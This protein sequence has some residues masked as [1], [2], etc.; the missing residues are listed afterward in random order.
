MP[1]EV[2]RAVRVSGRLREEMSRQ[3]AALRDPR[4]AG[5]LVT[6][7]E[8]TDDLQLARI[9]V[10][11]SG[12][13]GEGVPA[14]TRPGP[15]RRAVR[16]RPPGRACAATWPRRW[17]CATRPTSAS[18]GTRRPR[19]SAAS[20]SCYARSTPSAT[21]VTTSRVRTKRVARTAPG[22]LG[23]LAVAVGLLGG[24]ALAAGCALETRGPALAERAKAP[25]SRCPAP[26]RQRL[27]RRRVAPRAGGPGVLRGT[28][29][30]L[31]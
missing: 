19:R 9:Y 10:R 27:A 4:L 1:G 21:I 7:V 16:P 5:V 24:A 22:V 31:S 26:R 2:K 6:R 18:S 13:A 28:V 30:V 23:A 8:M 14:G 29:T 20:R 17:G 11:A 25:D 15:A 12:A 3:L